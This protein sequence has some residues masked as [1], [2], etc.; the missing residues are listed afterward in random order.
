[1]SFDHPAR[2][3]RT[4][5]ALEE[6]PLDALVVGVG[7]DMAWLTGYRAHELERLNVLALR[8]GR[9][10]TMV[11]PALE[12]PGFPSVE[13]IEIVPWIDGEDATAALFEVLGDV[14]AVGVGDTLR[15]MAVL[16]MLDRRPDIRLDLASTVIGSLRAR[17]DDE[18]IGRLKAA[19][20]AADA[21]TSHF[22]SGSASLVGRTEADVAAEVRA[23]LVD[24][25]HDT[26]EFSIVASGPN[27]ASPHHMPGDRVIGTGE[28][29]LF[30]IGGKLGGYSSD[31][32][33]CVHT[34]PAPAEI[35]EAWE[36]LVA[37]NEA[38]FRAAA[39]GTPCE[40]VDRAC[41]AVVADA[42]W[43]DRFIHR[44]GHGIGIEGHEHP[45]IVEGNLTPLEVGHAF[46]IEPGIYVE[47]RWGLRLEDIVVLEDGGPVRCNL[48]P[49]VLAEVG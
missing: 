27:A 40:E 41:R 35:A 49:R 30:D 16:P 11:M 47:G 29:V 2:L 20:A 8:P 45:Y 39:P 42:G 18:E 25:G 7:P 37:A 38:G 24:A 19:G 22:M 13:G 14:R 10:P 17:K 1:M 34:G 3:A 33:R 6:S 9:P 36:V 46:S 12:A 31:T 48:A 43:G 23:R 5:A 44:T 28:V 32:T 4:V 21:V 15:A 26:A